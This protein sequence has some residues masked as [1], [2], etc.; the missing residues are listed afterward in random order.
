MTLCHES[1]LIFP[2]AS[3]KSLKSMHVAI[4][5]LFH[6]FCGIECINIRKPEFPVHSPMDGHSV[7]LQVF[8]TTTSSIMNIFCVF[9]YMYTCFPVH[10]H[11]KRF[12]G[13]KEEMEMLSCRIVTE[14]LPRRTLG[15]LC[16]HKVLPEA[17]GDFHSNSLSSDSNS[18]RSNRCKPATSCFFKFPFL[19][20]MSN[21]EYF[22]IGLLTHLHFPF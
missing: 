19:W 22:L 14:L 2:V 11:E 9:L 20:L 15:A 12:E 13:I 21:V 6:L 10:F 5:D 16:W 7:C 3:S 17:G 1:H 18:C 8:A 4:N